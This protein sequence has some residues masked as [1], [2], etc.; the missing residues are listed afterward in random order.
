MPASCA[1]MERHNLMD[2]ELVTHRKR[3]RPRS[4]EPLS[5]LSTRIPPQQH[6]QLASI[7]R[8]NGESVSKI[9]RNVVFLFLHD[10]HSGQF[11]S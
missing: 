7:A 4:A 2:R 6:E 8:K 3:G 1:Q 9:L 5:S 11:P 10:D